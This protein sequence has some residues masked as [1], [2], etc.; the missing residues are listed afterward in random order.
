VEI[1]NKLSNFLLKKS[2]INLTDNDFNSKKY[3]LSETDSLDNSSIGKLGE[4]LAKKHYE[5]LGYK[6]I[7]T[8][9]RKRFGEIDIVAQNKGKVIFC[10]VKTRSSDRF[11]SAVESLTHTK[12]K[13]I[14][15]MIRYYCLKNKIS[16]ENIRADFIAVQINGDIAELKHFQ[17]IELI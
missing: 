2:N 10:E 8:N 13:R 6:I 9:A 15:R 14:L 5:D 12:K 7:E 4:D 17:N 3:N 11:G 16:N 1:L